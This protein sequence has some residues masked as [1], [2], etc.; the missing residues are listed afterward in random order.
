MSELINLDDSDV[1]SIPE[2]INPFDASTLKVSEVLKELEENLNDNFMELTR[3]GMKCEVLQ[4]NSRWCK[5]KVRF[6]L[7]FI[8]DEPEP[9]ASPLDDL[10]DKLNLDE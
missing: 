9:D 5:G 3:S 8:P 6:S 1:V 4:M 10:R 2:E 7:K